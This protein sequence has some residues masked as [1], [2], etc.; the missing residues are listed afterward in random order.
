MPAAVS[1]GAGIYCT[2]SDQ[3]APRGKSTC[4]PAAQGVGHLLCD[5]QSVRSEIN[6]G[7]LFNCVLTALR[8]HEGNRFGDGRDRGRVAPRSGQEPLQYGI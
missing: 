2:R 1:A 5:H 4:E 8:E 6:I 3:L 7:S